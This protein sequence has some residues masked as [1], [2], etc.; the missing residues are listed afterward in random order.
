MSKII[1]A[2]ATGMF[3]G[4]LMIF[5]ATDQSNIDD[6]TLPY[7]NKFT[8]LTKVFKTNSASRLS[9]IRISISDLKGETAGTCHYGFNRIVIDRG[10]WVTMSV[11]GKEE[12]MFHEL[13]HCILNLD[14]TETGLMKPA[15]FYQPHIYVAN[16]KKL[17][18]EL[19]GCKTGDCHDIVWDE[20]YYTEEFKLTTKQEILENEHAVVKFSAKWCPPCKL[21]APVFDEVAAAHPDVKVY[22]IDVDE[23]KDIAGEF[24]VRGIPA[25]LQI[26][27]G[28][29]MASRIGNVPKS[30]VE[31]LFK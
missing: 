2:I 5:P 24:G 11:V 28:K 1:G 4:L 9:S 16:Y 31:E 20:S 8:E 25:L 26:K 7:V 6:R 3:L 18:N 14:H 29:V 27:N 15:G 10:T 30:K 23:D 17:I 13:G 21:L 12:L 19:F 22:R